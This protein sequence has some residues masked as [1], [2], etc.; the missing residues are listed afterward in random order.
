M[1]I[2]LKKYKNSTELANLNGYPIYMNDMMDA[3]LRGR[4][5][6][7]LLGDTG[8]GKTQL[9]K[10]LMDYFPGKSLF[11]LGRNDMD[12]RELFQR[13]NPEFLRALKDGSLNSSTKLKELTDKINY[14]LIVNDELPNCVPSVRAQLFNLFDG[15]I[16]I[17]GK[18][19]SIGDGYSV[20]VAT[21]NMGQQ[22]TESSNDLGRALK[23]RM[24]LILDTDHYRPQPI[25][26][27]DILNDDRNP[28]VNFS[29]SLEDRSVD[30]KEKHEELKKREV[31]FD[32]YIIA[33]YLVHGL[34]YIDGFGSKIGMKSQWPNSL[35]GHSM[36]S[37]EALILPVSPRAA[38]SII[39]LS[40][41]LDQI[42]E[43]K[44]A[45]NLDYFNSMMTAFK[46]ASAYSG[47]LND[48]LI[49]SNYGGNHYGA[50]D[51]VI[52][53]TREQFKSKE[54]AI[55][56][57]YVMLNKGKMSK[58]ILDNFSGR[59]GFMKNLLENFYERKEK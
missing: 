39:T 35:E 40:Q 48:A 38:K 13:I 51:A 54:E 8:S 16:E 26:T 23:D 11:I 50:M 41:A 4:L 12:T 25:D 3:A 44:G 22:F 31:P 53:T 21:G 42:T 33:G 28:R 34:D 45:G 57:G 59:W 56:A 29:E 20:G 27:F 43:E 15:F 55:A 5:N 7:L 17:D 18:L 47:I 37:D 2:E 6:T 58:K 9:A 36:G 1:T 24:H 30:I 32:K 10:D 46:F 52:A 49:R 19:Y 14:N